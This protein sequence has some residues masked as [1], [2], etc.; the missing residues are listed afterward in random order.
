MVKSRIKENK[1]SD[2]FAVHTVDKDSVSLEMGRKL[3]IFIQKYI[4]LKVVQR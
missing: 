2:L 4:F 3:L 1:I